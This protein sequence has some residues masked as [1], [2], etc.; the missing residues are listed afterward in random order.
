MFLNIYNF[1]L[2]S[3]E[4]LNKKIL[5]IKTLGVL[6]LFLICSC[7]IQNNIVS[8]KN[9]SEYY[10][11]IGLISS[12]DPLIVSNIEFSFKKNQL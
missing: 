5:S 1:Y 12:L 7:S 2:L 6:I 4:F 10:G 3:F 9:Y 11:L 8:K